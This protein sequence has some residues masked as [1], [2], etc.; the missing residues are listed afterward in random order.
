MVNNGERTQADINRELAEVV[1]MYEAFDVVKIKTVEM[2]LLNKDYYR[3]I[4][5][6]KQCISESRLEQNH[7]VLAA[8]ARA[9][10]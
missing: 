3:V 4:F 5:L 8:R 2:A 1:R 9:F 7:R 10:S 6:T